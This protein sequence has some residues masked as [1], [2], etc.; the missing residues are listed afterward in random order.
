MR[1]LLLI[2]YRGTNYCG[3]QRQINGL[4]VQE[5]VERAIEEIVG[6][7]VTVFASGRTD[8]GVHAIAQAAHFD[9]FGTIPA[10]KFCF[11]LNSGLPKDISVSSSRQVPED[12]HARFSALAKTYR[13]QIF[14]SPVRHALKAE[15]HYIINTPLDLNQMRA[16]ARLLTGTHDFAAFSAKGSEPSGTVRTLKQILIIPEAEYVE[17]GEVVVEFTADGF[18][19]NMV[20]VLVKQLLLVATNKLSLDRIKMILESR[21][22]A[23]AKELA[24]PQGLFLKEVYY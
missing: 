16:A 7:P 1:V 18:L 21:D 14:I 17:S 3:W 9:Y 23:N 12:F 15:T 8:A 2:E 20:R 19:Y 13:Y 24:P 11:A 6:K 5:V 10:E 22:R 4:S